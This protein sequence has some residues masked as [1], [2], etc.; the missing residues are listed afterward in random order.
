M[1]LAV[2]GQWFRSRARGERF[3]LASTGSSQ[4][5]LRSQFATLKTYCRHCL[6]LVCSKETNMSEVQL[7]PSTVQIERAILLI[8]GHKVILDSDL[9]MLYGA[10][11]K[12][13]NEQVRRNRRRFP[14]DFMIQLTVEES[15]S[16][17]SQ[18]ATLKTGRG[19]H[20]KYPPY[21]FTEQGVAM[22][23][24]VLNSDR[25][26]EVNI[27]IMRAFVR[28]REILA[29]HKDLARKLEDLERKLGEHDEKFQV[30]FEAIRQLMAPPPEPKRGRIGFR[31]P[32]ES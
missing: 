17:R 13:L 11:T 1:N 18:F 12:R 16:L 22:L 5:S 20:R 23:S 7:V 8:R 25:A 31:M 21:A 9:A 10:S 14:D 3:G 30:V 6:L 27:A 19:R 15:D 28:L 24:S 32:D 2:S 29:S 4:L 26:I